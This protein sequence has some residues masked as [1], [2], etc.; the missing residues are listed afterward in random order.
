LRIVTWNEGDHSFVSEANYVLLRLQTQ[1]D[2]PDKIAR[3]AGR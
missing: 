1:A 2:A 3:P